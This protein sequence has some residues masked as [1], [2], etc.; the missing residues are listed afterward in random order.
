MLDVISLA[1]I[2]I[3]FIATFLST[4]IATPVVAAMMRRRGITGRDVHKQKNTQI[5]EMGGLAILLSLTIGTVAT[6]M[7]FPDSLRQ[8]VAFIGAVLIA[9]AIGIVDDLHPLSART[10][11]ILT[12]IAC[13]PILLLKTYNS[14]A[15]IPFF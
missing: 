10:K 5:P 8:G 6:V 2:V 1:S 14:F 9:G 15:V 7:I 11:P 4:F 3:A 12:A 13:L